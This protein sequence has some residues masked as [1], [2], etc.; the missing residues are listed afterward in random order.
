MFYFYVNSF[1]FSDSIEKD[2]DDELAKCPY[3]RFIVNKNLNYGFYLFD[4]LKLHHK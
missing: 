2:W 3:S 1:L 4:D